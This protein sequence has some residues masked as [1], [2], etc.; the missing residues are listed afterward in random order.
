MTRPDRR[1]HRR[2]STDHHTSGFGFATWLGVILLGAFVALATVGRLLAGSP[3]A[4]VAAGLEPPSL[5][6][7]FGT[8]NIGRDLFSRT[9]H[10]AWTSL[11]TSGASILLAVLIA[12]PIGIY[13]AWSSDRWPDH[14]LMRTVE[15]TQIVPQFILAVL[16]LGLTGTG[17][18]EIWGITISMTTRIIG[19][20]AIGFLP[21]FARIT[22]S[23]AVVELEEEYVSGLRLLGV[24]NREL[25]FREVL[26]NV[27]PVIGVQVF[28][29]LAIAVFAEGG[30]SFLALGVPAP[31]PTLGNLIAEAGGQLLDGGWWY[32]L[33]PGL[34]LVA[35]ITGC[36]LVGD[37]AT[38][39]VIGARRAATGTDTDPT[40]LI[41]PAGDLHPHVSANP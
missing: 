6:H 28:L 7:P 5:A 37:A 19:C 4:L 41:T 14:V 10:G 31:A 21:F 30:L 24:P 2:T 38:D 29:A 17:D 26:P 33:I 18:V 3:T 15:T 34:V 32:A 36:N 22:R 1:R 13:A 23:A 27:A 39:R 9:A 20:L 11:T 35:G 25:L 40:L 12:V 8:D 16:I